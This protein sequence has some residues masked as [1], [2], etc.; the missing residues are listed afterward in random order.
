MPEYTVSVVLGLIVVV[1][2]ELAWLRTGLFKTVRYWASMAIVVAFQVLVDGL[3]TRGS[4]PVV[5]YDDS[6]NLGIRLPP[7]IPIEDFAFGFALCTAVLLV[8]VRLTR[9]AP[10]N[11]Q[12][13]ST[14]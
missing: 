2:L 6:Q 3:L 8:W 5:A 14:S 12:P 11:S 13:T 10:S 1:A 4:E 7:G 9:R